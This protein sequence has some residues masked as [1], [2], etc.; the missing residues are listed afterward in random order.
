MVQAHVALSHPGEQTQNTQNDMH[1]TDY[2]CITRV[3]AA[4]PRVNNQLL[5]LPQHFARGGWAPFDRSL[6]ITF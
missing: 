3:V 1:T 6:I 5:V 4:R 2:Y